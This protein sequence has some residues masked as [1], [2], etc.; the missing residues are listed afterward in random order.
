MR[1]VHLIGTLKK[2]CEDIFP[3]EVME[4]ICVN[5]SRKNMVLSSLDEFAKWCS[6]S[7]DIDV[8]IKHILPCEQLDIDTRTNI[9]LWLLRSKK[10]SS[11]QRDLLLEQ[12]EHLLPKRR[13]VSQDIR[14]TLRVEKRKMTSSRLDKEKRVKLFTQEVVANSISFPL[15]TDVLINILEY[16]GTMITWKCRIICKAFYNAYRYVHPSIPIPYSDVS[17]LLKNAYCF[18][19]TVSDSLVLKDEHDVHSLLNEIR[20]VQVRKRM[21]VSYHTD[22]YHNDV[23]AIIKDSILSYEGRKIISNWPQPFGCDTHP[24]ELTAELSREC[25]IYIYHMNRH[26]QLPVNIALRCYSLSLKMV[27]DKGLN[28]ASEEAI[29]IV[30]KT[31]NGYKFTKQMIN[32]EHGKSRIV[33]FDIDTLNEYKGF[34]TKKPINHPHGIIIVG[35]HL[36]Y[37]SEDGMN[38]FATLLNEY[39]DWFSYNFPMVNV[40]MFTDMFSN[41]DTGSESRI[42]RSR[43]TD[44]IIM[45]CKSTH[46]Y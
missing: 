10:P 24:H 6:R 23:Y 40:F 3:I 18:L 17:T 2:M 7:C 37:S 30:K 9:T 41:V 11:E 19:I 43:S 33:C 45:S 44:A 34:Y 27:H 15:N 46:I 5:H 22:L 8:V 13:E 16:A 12:R 35:S 36:K 32:I 21:D 4:S 29:D 31:T 25:E 28:I 14:Q 26:Y 20:E 42:A 39:I 38:R 1:T